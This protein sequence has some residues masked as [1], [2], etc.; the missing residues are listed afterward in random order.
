[1]EENC[2]N[3]LDDDCDS[4]EDELDDFCFECTP[5][6][7]IGCDT[8]REGI[9]GPGYEYCDAGFWDPCLPIEG[10]VREICG[11]GRDDD[12]QGDDDIDD[13]ECNIGVCTVPVDRCPTELQGI[14][15]DGSQTCTDG[16]WS[17]CVPGVNPGDQEESIVAGTC[18]DE[19]DNDCDGDTD[20]DDIGCDGFCEAAQQCMV[21]SSDGTCYG[22]R[23]C[24]GNVLQDC[25]ARDPVSEICG[26]GI[27]D[28]CD[29][30]R[31]CEDIA[32]CRGHASC[33]EPVCQ[34]GDTV[35]SPTG[36]YGV[37][38]IGVGTCVDGQWETCDQTIFGSFECIPGEGDCPV[39]VDPNACTN[40]LNDDCDEYDYDTDPECQT[41]P[42]PGGDL[43]L[44]QVFIRNDEGFRLS[45]DLVSFPISFEDGSVNG[46]LES[47]LSDVKIGSLPTQVVATSYYKDNAQGDNYVRTAM[48]RVLV[49]LE[50]G[51]EVILPIETG[52]SGSFS[53]NAGVDNFLN[54]GMRVV[55]KDLFGGEYEVIF[56]KDE[57]ELVEDGPVTKVYK[58]VKRH[59]PVGGANCVSGHPSGECLSYMFFGDFIC[60]PW[61]DCYVTLEFV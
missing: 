15:E 38:S 54:G 10:P 49:S 33:V 8:G 36:T 2:T 3:G 42:N 57:A 45:S 18:D 55:T 48:A 26:N 52:S 50:I 27:D 31:D 24:V 21:T 32:V 25:D 58:M 20:T 30:F 13:P 44:D 35:C 23:D 4:F 56:D 5:E 1:L 28:N 14:C 22:R 60:V 7:R 9:C 37:C 6:E 34:A 12:C 46:Y 59:R 16:V 51:Q 17:D 47:E 40:G 29:G 39:G 43:G 11:N 19:L 61:K 53:M 41:N